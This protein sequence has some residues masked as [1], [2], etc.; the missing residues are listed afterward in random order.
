MRTWGGS[1][2]AHEQ[3]HRD[4]V[5][6]DGDEEHAYT[7]QRAVFQLFRSDFL[8]NMNLFNRIDDQL[9]RAIQD[10]KSGGH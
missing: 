2:L 8:G 10:A 5:G 3:V 7:R 4:Y 6:T 9:G 1:V